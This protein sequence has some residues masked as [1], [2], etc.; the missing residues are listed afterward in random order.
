[1]Y[2]ENGHPS[3]SAGEMDFFTFVPGGYLSSALMWILI[4]LADI[5]HTLCFLVIYCDPPF[6][7]YLDYTQIFFLFFLFWCN[8]SLNGGFDG[9]MKQHP[10]YLKPFLPAVFNKC[11]A[12]F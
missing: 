1:M 7:D 2:L 11:P 9:Q 5:S 3:L 10:F 4:P 8:L 12:N 6:L